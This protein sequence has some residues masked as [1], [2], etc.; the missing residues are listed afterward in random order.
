MMPDPAGPFPSI[1]A[2]PS[3]YT[4]CVAG[5]GYTLATRYHMMVTQ[6]GAVKK[7]C[8]LR[9]VQWHTR[10]MSS[11]ALRWLAVQLHQY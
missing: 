1:F 6:P 8:P 2:F 11:F 5:I 9:E 7:P 4:V 10:T 3:N